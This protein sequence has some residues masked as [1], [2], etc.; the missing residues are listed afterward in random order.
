M[1]NRTQII[2]NLGANPELRYMADG[3]AVCNFSVAVN[4]GNDRPAVWYRVSAWENQ[5][6]NCAKYLR[7]GSKVMVEGRARASAYLDKQGQPQASLELTARQVI[8][9]SEKPDDADATD[10]PLMDIPF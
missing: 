2:G 1:L 3:K 4:E 10:E 6:E 8:F 5:A 7:K 9:L